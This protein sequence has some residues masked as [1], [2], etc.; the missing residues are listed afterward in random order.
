VAGSARILVWGSL[1]D[2]WQV[3]EGV[4]RLC[5]ELRIVSACFGGLLGCHSVLVV[6]GSLCIVVR[7]G[8]AIVRGMALHY[9]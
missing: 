2:G 9:F 3:G 6:V 8:V 5:S 1:G 7:V 4:F